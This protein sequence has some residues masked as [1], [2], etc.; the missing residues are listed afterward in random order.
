MCGAEFVTENFSLIILIG[1]LIA[2]IVIF[3]ELGG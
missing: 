2:C 3:I 1:V